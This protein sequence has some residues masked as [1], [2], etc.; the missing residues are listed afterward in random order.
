M[1]HRIKLILAGASALLALVAAGPSHADTTLSFLID[2]NPDTV[3]A[4][5]ALVA[6]YQAKAPDVTIE[7]EPRAGGGEGDNIIK[8]R[9]ATG[10]MSDVFLYNSGSLL[11]ALKP[12]QTLVDLSGLSSQAKVD[13][14][15]KSVVRADGKIYGVP[16]GTAM[17]GGILYNRKIYQDL[18]LSVPKTWADFMANNAKVKASGKVAV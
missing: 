8:T 2:N 16:F 14:S 12:T 6:A 1:T 17:A 9:L 7:I 13:E 15:F 4:A 18:G 3:A 11:Q 10:E 5:E